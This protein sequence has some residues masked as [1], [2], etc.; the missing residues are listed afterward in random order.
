MRR[1]ATRLRTSTP[2]R[3]DEDATGKGAGKGGKD[4]DGER[5][6]VPG[7][8]RKSS[9]KRNHKLKERWKA[10]A[11]LRAGLVTKGLLNA[12]R[13]GEGKGEAGDET[14]DSEGH[15]LLEHDLEDG[16]ISALDAMTD[17]TPVANP[18]GGPSRLTGAAA[19]MRA[20]VA[21]SPA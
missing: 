16:F 11:D 18:I 15:E 17:R 4:N 1:T 3:F 6:G 5:R 21:A 14:R 20:W 7:E 2:V 9:G 12:V 8:N 13:K 19:A 10:C